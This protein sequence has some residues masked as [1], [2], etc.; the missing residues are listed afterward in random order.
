MNTVLNSLKNKVLSLLIASL[1]LFIGSAKAQ[2]DLQVA[3]NNTHHYLPLLKDKKIGLVVNATSVIFN[4]NSY[5]HLVDSLLSHRVTI[6]TIFSPE[7]GFRT[8]AD[9]GEKVSDEIDPKSGLPIVSLY[10]KN[11]KPKS[12][13]LKELDLIVFDIQDVGVRFYT[14]IATLQLVMEACAENN[15]PLIVFDRPNPNG[16]YIDGPVLEKEHSSFLGLNEIP[17]VYGMTIGEYALMLKGEGWLRAEQ[18]LDLKV[19]PLT[20]YTHQSSYSIPIKPSPNL[21]DDQAIGLYPS[22][23]LFEGTNVN[24]GRGTSNQFSRFG[25]SFLNKNHFDFSY[26]PHPNPGSKYPK[27]DGKICYGRDLSKSVIPHKVSLKWLIEAYENST[28]KSNYFRTA[29]FTKHAGT[30]L[31]QQQIEQG[32]SEAQ[33]RMS[34]QKDINKFKSIRK[35]YLLYP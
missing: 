23:G 24:A 29:G 13:Q 7:H 3:A 33:I 35:K 4:K 8:D 30:T 20:G 25:A 26:T 17:L 27:E 1:F 5:T 11:R 14:Y 16:S 10:G 31:L 6:K 32:L 21:P 18:D 12:E 28:D 34:W 19:I 9:A 15:I 22:L 2:S